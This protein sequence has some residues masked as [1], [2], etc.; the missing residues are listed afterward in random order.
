MRFTYKIDA[1][2]AAA[3]SGELH[4]LTTSS[5]SLCQTRIENVGRNLCRQCLFEGGDLLEADLERCGH[6]LFEEVM[7]LSPSF[8]EKSCARRKR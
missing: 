4:L 3:L 1:R 5:A 8:R 7:Y 6:G 2:M